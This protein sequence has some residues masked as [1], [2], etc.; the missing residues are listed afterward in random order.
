MFVHNTVLFELK[1]IGN[2]KKNRKFYVSVFGHT[3]ITT[4]I[5]PKHFPLK[6]RELDSTTRFINV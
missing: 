5:W 3:C 4:V 1:N 6:G 2:N